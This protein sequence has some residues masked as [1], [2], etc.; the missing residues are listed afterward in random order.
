MAKIQI[1]TQNGRY[2]WRSFLCLSKNRTKYADVTPLTVPTISGKTTNSQTEVTY[3]S[4]S[5]LSKGIY[6]NRISLSWRDS[7]AYHLNL[8]K[9]KMLEFHLV[10]YYNAYV[11]LCQNYSVIISIEQIKQTKS[12]EWHVRSTNKIRINSRFG[13]IQ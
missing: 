11:K 2:W 3:T 5:F 1:L 4:P 12:I 6:I 9:I 8:A 7:T 13:R 10:S